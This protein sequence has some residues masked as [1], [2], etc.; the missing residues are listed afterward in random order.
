MNELEFSD[1]NAENLINRGFAVKNDISAA[2]KGSQESANN[3]I[4][5]IRNKDFEIGLHYCTSSF[6]DGIQLKNRIMRRAKNIVKKY[7]VISDDGTLL[8]GVIYTLNMSLQGLYKTLKQEY[9]IDDDY[10]FINN[11]KNRIEVAVWILEKIALDL[12]K[13]GIESYMVEEYPT[14]D[15]LEVERIPLPL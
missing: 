2:V 5:K 4:S 6:K 7:E 1:T 11:E 14:A 15:G 13:R 3:I 10:I 8:K 12:K 9:G